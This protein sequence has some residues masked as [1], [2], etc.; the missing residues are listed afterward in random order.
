M[1]FTLELPLQRSRAEVW[2]AFDN[3]E[4]TKKWQPTLVKF[5]TIAGM[6]G[7]PGALSMLT[8]AEGKGEFVLME[9][10]TYRAEPERFDVV[11]ENNFA[12]NSVKNTFTATSEND[13]LWKM[14]VEFKFKT[15]L[16]KVIGPF[17]KKN[18]VKRSQRDMERFKEF[19]EKFAP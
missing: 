3:S 11:Y 16:M 1:K 8:Y 2:R 19:V 5:Q 18:F 12:D 6:Q 10:V 15:L 7:Q 17:A 4:N 13:T 9:K 14:E